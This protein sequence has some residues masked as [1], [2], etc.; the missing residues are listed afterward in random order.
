MTVVRTRTERGHFRAAR[1]S[2][3]PMA[4]GKRPVTIA[5]IFRGLRSKKPDIGRSVRKV[6]LLNGIT[7]IRQLRRPYQ[8]RVAVGLVLQRQ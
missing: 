7:E 4:C 1:E 2:V 8:Q 6:A 5:R 3:R